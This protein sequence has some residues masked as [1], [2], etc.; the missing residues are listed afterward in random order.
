[1]STYAF[2]ASHSAPSSL[3]VKIAPRSVRSLWV[4]VAGGV[5]GVM[6]LSVPVAADCDLQ[7]RAPMRIASAT[8]DA[9]IGTFQGDDSGAFPRQHRWSVERVVRGSVA[10]D[11]VTYEVIACHGLNAFVEGR[12]YLVSSADLA[13]PDA[14]NTVAWELD[15]DGVELVA[16]EL[17][18]RLYPDVWD[19]HDLQD[20]L[21]LVGAGQLP[22]T[23]MATVRGRETSRP[24]T[25][26]R[27]SAVF[28]ASFALAWLTVSRR[29]VG[30]PGDYP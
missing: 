16:F 19:V 18:R 28:V 21:S 3:L 22:P 29:R 26:W 23:A 10:H 13:A 14:G 15:G 6:L 2:Q 30:Q 9:F 4:A 5:V 12:T 27:L 17:P 7:R 25:L 24:D 8:G 11:P 1:M 20:A